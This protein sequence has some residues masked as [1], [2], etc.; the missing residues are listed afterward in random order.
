M[1]KILKTTQIIDSFLDAISKLCI[2]CLWALCSLVFFLAIALNFSYVNSSLD[3]MSMYCFG[4][5]VFLSLSYT[6][7]EG[8]HV[9]L[10]LLYDS[11]PRRWRLM[12]AVIVD[13][14]FIMPFC[15]VMM[16]YGFDFA[17]QSYEISESSPN[18]RIP[19][20]F[21]FKSFIVVGFAL[22]FL[23]AFCNGL[24]TLHTL[25]QEGIRRRRK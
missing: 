10:D 17:L 5:M 18:A 1:Q 3:D 15:Y 2:A 25:K 13:F 24:K 4:L 16:D 14:F 20:Y 9:R 21:I 6:L 19:F 23:S 11:Y 22:L 12:S 8:R 7:K